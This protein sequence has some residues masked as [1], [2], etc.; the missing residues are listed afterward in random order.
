MRSLQQILAKE[1]VL[2]EWLARHRH[3]L[4]LEQRVRSTLPPALAAQIGVAA[5]AAPELVLTAASG[6]AA[7]LLRQR[8]PEILEALQREGWKFTGI[9]VRVQ[10]R[11]APARTMKKAAKQ[12]DSRSAARLQA[13]ASALDDPALKAALQRLA[14]EQTNDSLTQTEQ[15]LDHK[16]DEDAQQ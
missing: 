5:A 16:K 14:G 10:V 15:T 2:A 9:R 1:S 13:L 6:A 3:E 12:I 7:A 11:S 8:V 4:G